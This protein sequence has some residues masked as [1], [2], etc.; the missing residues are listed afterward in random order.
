M[1]R[2]R[3]TLANFTEQISG[4]LFSLRAEVFRTQ[5]WI[6]HE[7]P[8]YWRAQGRL[9]FDAI[10]SA[11]SNLET[12][13]MRGKIAGHHPVCYDEQLALRQAKQRLQFANDQID[14]ARRWG[15]K[16]R[17]EAE[18]YK[19]IL[20]KLQQLLDHDLVMLQATLDGMIRALEAYLAGMPVESSA[21]S[22][23]NRNEMR[24]P[25]AVTPAEHPIAV[26][27]SSES[28][29]LNESNVSTGIEADRSME[30]EDHLGKSSK[31]TSNG[32]T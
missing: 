8:Q 5:E 32:S 27:T 15:N 22:I 12:A 19:G 20:G 29:S 3:Q 18:E 21:P 6:E 7:C 10:A 31:T 24:A 23:F 4:A 1:S 9:A 2:F 28:N 17:H 13:R 25:V 14:V 30:P 26:P 16:F 11:R